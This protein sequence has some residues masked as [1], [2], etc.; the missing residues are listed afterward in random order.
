MTKPALTKLVH[1]ALNLV[2]MGS[3]SDDRSKENGAIEEKAK[4][5]AKLKMVSIVTDLVYRV[6]GQYRRTF[7]QH[8]CK[9][10]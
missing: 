3:S 10:T 5:L 6:A 1:R 9:D 4:R 8:W 2:K 7:C